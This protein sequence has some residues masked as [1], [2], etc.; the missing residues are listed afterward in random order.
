VPQFQFEALTMR[1]VACRTCFHELAVDAP[2]IDVAQPRWVG[3]EYESAKRRI[4]IVM[5]NPGSGESRTDDADDRFRQL[6]RAFSDGSGS[7][8]AVLR[9]EACDMVN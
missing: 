4:A 8:D 1:A 5:L 9:H 6:I 2:L 7:L 3:P